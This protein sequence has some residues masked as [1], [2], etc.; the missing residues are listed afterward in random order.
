MITSQGHA[1][2]Q[3]GRN[4]FQKLTG[5]RL[6]AYEAK[7][8]YLFILPWVLGFLVFTLG[9]MLASLF[10]SFCRYN[11]LK[12]PAWIGL[13]NYRTMVSGGDMLFWKSVQVTAQYVVLRVPLHVLGALAGAIILNQAIRGRVFYRAL[14]FIPSI[15]PSVAALMVWTWLLNADYGLV[16]SLL[17][18]IGVQGPSWLGDPHWAVHSL[19]MIGLWSSVGGA[20]AIIFLSALQDIPSSYYEAAQVDGANW[21]DLQRY[22]TIP[23]ITPAMFLVLVLSVISTFQVFTAAYVATGG[24]PA[25]ATYFYVLHLYNKAFQNYNMGYASALAW[26]LAVVLLALTWLQ[27]KTSQRWV[28]YGGE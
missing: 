26:V 22:I 3:G 8:G 5:G 28:F 19:V 12:P 4:W 6:A 13:E 14:F 18:G 7:W 15:T 2:T 25:Y 20:D 27:Q 21:W 24:G 10:F 17:A 23:L 11:V 16:N 9:P 1:I